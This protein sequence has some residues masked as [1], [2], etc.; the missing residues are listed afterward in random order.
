MD[1]IVLLILFN[2]K[3]E[4][5]LDRLR[6]IYSNRFSKLYFIMP[7]YKGFDENVI[8]VYGNSLYYRTYIAQALKNIK[9][10]YKH[11]IIIGDDLLLNPTINEHN[12]KTEFNLN[13]NTGFIPELF[14]LDNYKTQPRLLMPDFKSWVWNKNAIK[15]DY[16]KQYGIEVEKE[17]PAESIALQNIKQHGYIFNNQLGWNQLAGSGIKIKSIF[18]IKNILKNIRHIFLK[19]GNYI[20]F[21]L[22]NKRKL[23]YPLVGSY[24]DIVI[25]PENAID[26]FTHYYGIFGALNLF[27]EI[28]IPTALILS[29]KNISQEKDLPQKGITHRKYDESQ[30]LKAKHNNNLNDLFLHFPK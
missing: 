20:T 28:T 25:I 21:L 3:Y 8:C 15:F 12:Y 26:D 29:S 7:F 18:D 23:K 30:S 4:A 1:K 5:N 17:L 24:S 27:V 14:T 19:G 10:R 13:D 2:H 9:K 6:T 16:R 22:K 11:Y